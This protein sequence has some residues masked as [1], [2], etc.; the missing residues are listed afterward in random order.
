MNKVYMIGNLT[1]DPELRSTQMGVSVCSFS[2]AVNRRFKGADGKN[3][4]DF[5]TVSAW[6]KLGENCAQYLK[7]GSKVAVTGAIQSRSYQA[8]DGSK[9]IAFDIVADEVEFLSPVQGAN[10]EQGADF[11]A[12]PPT[13]PSGFTEVDDDELP[14]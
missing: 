1:R 9:R 2:I 11:P 8:A 4:T 13:E 3:E 12:P 7:K 5:F 10:R 6:R 14:F